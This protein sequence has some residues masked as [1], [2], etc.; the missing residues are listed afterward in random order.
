MKPPELKSV[1]KHAFRPAL[2]GGV[3]VVAG[4]DGAG[5]SRLADGL[6]AAARGRGP[7]RRIHHRIRILPASEGSRAATTTPHSRPPYPR[8]LSFLKVFYL[9]LDEFLGWSLTVRP[10][11]H[12]G[13]WVIIERGWWDL[14]VDPGRYRLHGVTALTR[15]LGRLL[16][17]PDAILIL[18]AAP[19]IIQGRKQ[20]LSAGE[21]DR[22]LQ[23]WRAL[24]S[25][26]RGATIVDAFQAPEAVLADALAACA[27][28]P[29]RAVSASVVSR[30]AA[31][32]SH[33]RPRWLIPTSSASSAEAGLAIYQPMTLSGRAG[34]EA[35]LVC[36]RLG[37]FGVI[38]PSEDAA[39]VRTVAPF[40]PPG[41]SFS[42]AYGRE[43]NR[44]VVLI[45]DATAQP[46]AV[47]KLGLE[48][49]D[50]DRL[51][52][53]GEV[54]QHVSQLLKPPLSAPNVI[55]AE[56][57]VLV[58]EPIAWR[59]RLRPWRLTPDLAE[60]MGRF[61]ANAFDGTLSHPAHGDFAPWN[62][63]LTDRGWTLV[64]WENATEDS[65][66]FGDPFHY[67]VSAHTLLGRPT[68]AELLR[69][70]KGD[71][72]VGA[73]LAAYMNGAS[74][75]GGVRE[76]FVDYLRASSGEL[77]PLHPHTARGRESRQRLLVALGRGL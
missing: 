48:T 54:L 64:D 11:V 24:A 26:V 67:L 31:L 72:W 45:L 59:P 17:R 56:D 74:I 69:G 2:A 57:G 9:F 42:V 4:P 52:R 61:Y 16:P 27:L 14:A 66:P 51:R 8:W 29:P 40:V 44:A 60:A 15:L 6:M 37:L 53:E 36:A 35:A 75:G 70:L 19:S 32:P 73:A 43:P 13:G 39:V 65:L 33:A 55:A 30:W 1:E 3:I 46:T 34:W 58:I 7:V 47:A 71:G 41:G 68:Q 23:S 10:I 62:V 18:D 25:R 49:V 28:S 76:A 21:I 77:R 38:R 22:Q 12:R 63:L 5:K 50:R 20:E